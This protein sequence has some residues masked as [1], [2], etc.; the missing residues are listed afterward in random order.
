VTICEIIGHLLVIVQSK[1]RLLENRVLWKA[2][3]PKG[4]EERGKWRRLC[5]EELHDLHSLTNIFRMMEFRM[6][7]AGHVASTRDRKGAYRVL[8]E[9]PKWKRQLGRPRR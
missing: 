3:G 8:V 9:R 1:P 2:L 6:R 5:K 4:D 7:W